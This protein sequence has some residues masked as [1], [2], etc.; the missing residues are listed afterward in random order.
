MWYLTLCTVNPVFLQ[1]QPRKLFKIKVLKMLVWHL[2]REPMK[3]I[4]SLKK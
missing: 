4:S 1:S 3:E 2:S